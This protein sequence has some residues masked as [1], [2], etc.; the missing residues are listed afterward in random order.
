[1]SR[2]TDIVL[3]YT[4]CTVRYIVREGEEHSST[5]KQRSSLDKRMATLITPR[6]VQRAQQ[7]SSDQCAQQ[8]KTCRFAFDCII[9]IFNNS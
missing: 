6:D 7:Y 3:K 4:D 2:K 8:T 9:K 5:N 1:M